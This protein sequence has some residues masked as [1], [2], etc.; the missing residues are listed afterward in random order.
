MSRG[1]THMRHIH[2]FSTKIYFEVFGIYVI[3][4]NIS[5]F[6]RENICKMDSNYPSFCEKLFHIF[7]HI[8][9][10]RAHNTTRLT[11]RVNQGRKS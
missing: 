3:L 11:M 4:A 1:M 2:F 8:L 7:G 10:L 6:Y 9:N 5:R